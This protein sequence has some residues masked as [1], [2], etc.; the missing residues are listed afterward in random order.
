MRSAKKILFVIPITFALIHFFLC[1]LIETGVIRSE[2]SWAWFVIFLIDF[3]FSILLLKISDLT[4]MFISFGILG[5]LWWY[6]ISLV[7]SIMIWRIFI[8]QKKE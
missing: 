7:V 1:V 5:S 4:T 8:K 2:G 6:L 3:P